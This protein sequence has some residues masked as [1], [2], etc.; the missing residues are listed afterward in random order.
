LLPA[1]QYA[2]HWMT[3]GEVLYVDCR[4]GYERKLISTTEKGGG[5][6]FDGDL[7][8][9]S[10]FPGRRVI[11]KFLCNEKPQYPTRGR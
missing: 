7:C 6:C 2:P 9:L 5:V 11:I 4:D 3:G 10:A 1:N 8:G